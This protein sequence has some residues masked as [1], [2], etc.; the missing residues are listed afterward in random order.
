MDIDIVTLD[1]NKTE[2]KRKLYEAKETREQLNKITNELKQAK[3]NLIEKINQ[4]RKEGLMHKERRDETNLNV[5]RAKKHRREL[6]EEY[7]QLKIKLEDERKNY[8]PEGPSLDFL[9]IKRDELEFKQMTQQLR[10]REEEELIEQL[11][12][13]SR[14][15]KQREAILNGNAEL[16]GL[17][18]KTQELK[19]KSDKE[20]HKVQELAE[21][22]QQ[23]HLEMLKNFAHANELK[24]ELKKVEREYILNRLN[25]DKSHRDFISYI[26][27]IRDIEEAIKGIID[28]EKRIEIEKEKSALTQMADDIYEKFKKGEKLST[29]DLLLLQKAGLI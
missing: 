24:K 4:Y 26:K 1:K 27:Q 16:M 2:L 15:I 20:H 12:G 3:N 10:K 21:K 5:A 11:A 17:V 14:E 7:E 8:F 19:T 29:E 22:A 18:K 9:K 25:A 6:N 28:T 13:V 23:E